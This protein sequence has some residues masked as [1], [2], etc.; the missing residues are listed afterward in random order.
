MHAAAARVLL[1]AGAKTDDHTW[2]QSPLRLA[3]N[4][5]H[6]E[7]AA[8]LLR[9]GANANASTI[10]GYTPLVWAALRGH[11]ETT[12]ALVRASADP[13]YGAD[14]G[15]RT[16]LTAAATEGHVH[17]VRQMVADGTKANA[18][19]MCSALGASHGDNL[20]VAGWTSLHLSVKRNVHP[21]VVHA[22]IGFEAD[23]NVRGFSEFA[24]LPL[25]D[26]KDYALG[27]RILAK[28]G[29]DIEARSA[30]TSTPLHRARQ[31]AACE[32]VDPLLNLGANPA[33]ADE[34]NRTPRDVV[35][36]RGTAAHTLF[37]F[38]GTHAGDSGSEVV[39][40]AMDRDASRAPL[41][42]TSG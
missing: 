34:D 24:P 17:V 40:P 10:V 7:L 25:A 9:H 32:A 29:A 3:C 21:A 22:L 23:V 35:D 19:P 42:R 38:L 5:G 1:R 41:A 14:R 31:F 8:E 27:V 13:E 2:Y 20:T 26:D 11:V 39:P 4:N 30:S 18:R 36:S 16:A 28:A 12:K 33:A 37:D 15:Y 6:H